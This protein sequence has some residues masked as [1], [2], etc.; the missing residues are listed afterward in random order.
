MCST[1]RLLK[2]TVESACCSALLQATYRYCRYTGHVQ[3]SLVVQHF[4]GIT[5]TR[6]Q[7]QRS[8]HVTRS[9]WFRHAVAAVR[10]TSNQCSQRRLL[11]TVLRLKVISVPRNNLVL[12]CWSRQ[13][14]LCFR[15]YDAT[16]LRC[17]GFIYP[18]CDTQTSANVYVRSS[19]LQITE[20]VDWQ[21]TNTHTHTLRGLPTQHGPPAVSIIPGREEKQRERAASWLDLNSQVNTGRSR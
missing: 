15:R 2:P 10:S 5:G 11:V 6:R 1:S 18:H 9:C 7:Q 3:R 8:I 12:L 14:R 13:S 16:L 21:T 17:K 20:S 4:T 19:D